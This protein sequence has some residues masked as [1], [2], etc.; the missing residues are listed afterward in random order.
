MIN[1]FEA[2]ISIVFTSEECKQ[3]SS[4]MKNLFK[5]TFLKFWIIPAIALGFIAC[6]EGYEGL[7]DSDKGPSM[8]DGFYGDDYSGGEITD[9]NG[10]GDSTIEAGQITAGE[11]NDLNNWD[12]W[13]NLYQNEDVAG[14]ADYWK[15]DLTSRV[16]VLLKDNNANPIGNK[17]VEL[18]SADG[19]LLWASKTDKFGVAEL[20]P[21]LTG[22]H[23]MDNLKLIVDGN[24]YSD[25][26]AFAQGINEITTNYSFVN[27]V[28]GSIDIAFVVDATG[29]MS[30]ELEYLKV[31]LVDVID[32]VK[33]TNTSAS[34]NIAS[35]F[36]RDEG[37]EYVTRKN[38]F[39]SDITKTISFIQ[40][41]RADGGGDFPEA[42][43][44]ALKVAINELQ[45][46]TNVNS[47]V[48]F[49][50]LDAP[51]HY[52]TN[53]LEQVHQLVET[54]AEKGIKIIPITASG[55]DKETEFLMRYFSITTNGT[56]VFITNHSGIGG[57]HIEPTIGEY[58]VEYLNELL[59][60]LINKYL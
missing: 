11:W 31:E 33:E 55:I 20:W 12:F 6:E 36:Y 35:V 58:E 7:S 40:D 5:L 37:D 19:D 2:T 14:F 28:E 49:L 39:K 23:S 52:E 27:E 25:V 50:L 10:Q 15:F 41:Q 60:R 34:I 47:K 57:E 26:K 32:S 56:Y 48:L 21:S 53:I 3:Q 43:H 24:T 29:S 22:V 18:K 45:W 59:V 46:R 42:V 1:F 9:G 54:A 51:P 4:I 44:S 13:F 17:T 16:K 8:T 30:D 38:E